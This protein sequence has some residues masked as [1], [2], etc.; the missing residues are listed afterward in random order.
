[1]LQQRTQLVKALS[2]ISWLL[3]GQV[4]RLGLGVVVGI[5]IARH[6]G[7]RDFGLFSYLQAIVTL[8]GALASMG[9]YE[10]VVRNLVRSPDQRDQTLGT[11]FMLQLAGGFFAA[12]VVNISVL[13][14][15]PNDTLAQSIAAI[16]SITLVLR[17]SEA[18]KYWFEAQVNSKYVVW[19]ETGAVAAV[20]GIR[21]TLIFLDAG[22]TAFAYAALAEAT[23]T[24][25][26]LLIVYS[27]KQNRLR[28]WEFGWA[29]A[30][31][32]LHD[33]W[34]LILANVAV[35]VYIK[36]DQIM[37]GRMIGEEAVGVY[38]AA[39]RLSESWY[40]LATA[41]INSVF[42]A[43]IAARAVSEQAYR[44]RLQALYRLMVGIS[45]AVAVPV[46]FLSG[47]V[48]VLLFGPA[49]A[50]AGPVLATHIWGSLFVFL[51][52]ASGKALILDNRSDLSL[53]RTLAGAFMNVVLNLLLIPSYGI[54]GAA[55]ATIM[56]QAA[57]ALFYDLVHNATRDMFAMKLRAFSP[58]GAARQVADLYRSL[59]ADRTA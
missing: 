6:L 14:T 47:W 4:L 42:P 44:D 45:F 12:A 25:A 50:A 57:A 3:S 54:M 32:L 31:A 41:V 20:A 9:L 11:A 23:F 49:Y 43:I 39:V 28:D 22:V 58:L 34:P 16:L 36:T 8:A 29:R 27:R 48:T 24:S 10:V 5:W 33:A 55:Y 21:L 56:S 59:K 51:G 52:V 19:A 13:M 26:A 37:L 40:F 53:Q 38:S 46:T 35:L 2:N 17:A 15:E 7:P 18:V 30:R 1:M